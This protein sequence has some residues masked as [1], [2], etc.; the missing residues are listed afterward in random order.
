MIFSKIVFLANI[1]V[2]DTRY[3]HFISQNNNS[4][5]LFNSQLD[6][7][8]VNYFA[9][10]GS[11]KCKVDKFFTIPLIKLIT[12]KLLYYNTNRYVEKLSTIL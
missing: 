10:L 12:K 5:Y 3:K 4:L 9:K 8:L 11:I 2:L 7:A 6:Y 1:L